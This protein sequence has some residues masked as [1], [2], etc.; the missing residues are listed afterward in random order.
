MN[1]ERVGPLVVFQNRAR[2]GQHV[3]RDGP[4]SLA[5]LGTGTY[6]GFLGHVRVL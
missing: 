4:Q 6:G 3:A 2:V 1:R 5:D